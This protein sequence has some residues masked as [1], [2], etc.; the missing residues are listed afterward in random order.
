MM[1]M[2]FGAVAGLVTREIVLELNV[3]QSVH[4]L[5]TPVTAHAI[6]ELIDVEGG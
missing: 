2:F 4:A 3:E 5:H 6:G 1:A